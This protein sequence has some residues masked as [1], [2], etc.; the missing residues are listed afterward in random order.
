MNVQ[1]HHRGTIQ[2]LPKLFLSS[3]VD[4]LSRTMENT[5]NI[6]LLNTPSHSIDYGKIVQDI[7]T[8]IQTKN[9]LIISSNNIDGFIIF[10]IFACKYLDVE[11]LEILN[12]SK[13]YNIDIQ[14][15]SESQINGLIKC[16][17]HNEKIL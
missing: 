9:Y 5:H 15:F 14:H 11:W 6:N 2:V 3:G 4:N 17:S 12:L 1:T 10:G 13:Y 7:R 8:G 16:I